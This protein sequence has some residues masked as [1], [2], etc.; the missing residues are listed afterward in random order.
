MRQGS[1]LQMFVRE[2]KRI[3][4]IALLATVT[5]R[6]ELITRGEHPNY[7]AQLPSG[8]VNNTGL[9]LGDLSSQFPQF[10]FAFNGGLVG[11]FAYG[12]PGQL[13]IWAPPVQPVNPHPERSADIDW[14]SSDQRPSYGG[15]FDTRSIWGMPAVQP[16]S[17]TLT[18]SAPLQ[19]GWSAWSGTAPMVKSLAAAAIITGTN[20]PALTSAPGAVPEPG[21]YLLVGCGL[22]V[23][24]NC[25]RRSRTSAGDG[26]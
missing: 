15:S 23:F 13:I 18:A 6:G 4:L 2:M 24:F 21:S 20:E 16:G 17:G 8:G 5:L 3:A 9:S 10:D 22:I 7:D 25:L 12:R 1:G 19:T 11:H 26:R 14:R